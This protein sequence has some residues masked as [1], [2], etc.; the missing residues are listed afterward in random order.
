MKISVKIEKGKYIKVDQ[1]IK[2]QNT[3]QTNKQESMVRTT[4]IQAHD[5]IQALPKNI[6]LNETDN[7][8][9]TI[10]KQSF[11][12]EDSKN[13]TYLSQYDSSAKIEPLMSDVESKLRYQ[14]GDLNFVISQY[15][16]IEFEYI[17]D[18]IY[19]PLSANPNKEK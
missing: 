8:I 1:T 17:G 7:N 13:I 19:T 6:K 14:A 15:S 10:I 4:K 9:N 5:V 12:Q 18:P 11:I 2:L 16:E 3:R